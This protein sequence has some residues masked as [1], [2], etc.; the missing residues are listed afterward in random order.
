MLV[1]TFFLI[2]LQQLV[3]RKVVDQAPGL[4]RRSQSAQRHSVVELA[5]TGARE[6]LDALPR[7]QRDLRIEPIDGM[8]QQVRPR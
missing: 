1:A 6:R 2:G 5:S 3:S 8:Q 4:T 7:A